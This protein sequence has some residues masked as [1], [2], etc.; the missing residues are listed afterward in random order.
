[1]PSLKQ[2]RFQTGLLAQAESKATLWPTRSP[3]TPNLKTQRKREITLQFNNT[4]PHT[5]S[6]K[7]CQ[8]TAYHNDPAAIMNSRR[9]A[10]MVHVSEGPA[11]CRTAGQVR[12]QRLGWRDSRSSR[13]GRRS[14]CRIIIISSSKW[15][16]QIS[17]KS[18][19]TL[20]K[21]SRC[22]RI[23]SSRLSPS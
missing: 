6:R 7:P 23:N 21:S 8:T 2:C 5:W 16:R 20:R 10:L 9:V 22:S 4:K 17:S 13:R 1:M 12:R 19:W 18:D 3:K 14:L 11:V 15:G